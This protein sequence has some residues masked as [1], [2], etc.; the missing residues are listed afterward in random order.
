MARYVELIARTLGVI[1]DA[2]TL[3]GD[4]TPSVNGRLLAVKVLTGG[5]AATSL[6]ENGYIRLSCKSFGGVDMVAPFDGGGVFTAPRQKSNSGTQDT[7]CD[8]NIVAGVPIHVYYYNNVIPTT[9][10]ITVFAVVEG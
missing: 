9:P 6:I 8:L 3:I 1:I 2:D 4:W 7:G 10:E 5:I